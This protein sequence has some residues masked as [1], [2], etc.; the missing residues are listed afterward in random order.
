MN[1]FLIP[2]GIDGDIFQKNIFHGKF[3]LKMPAKGVP[4]PLSL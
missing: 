4:V 2:G 3:I 1:M